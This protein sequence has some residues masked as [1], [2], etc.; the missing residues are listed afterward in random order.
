MIRQLA[1]E[2]ELAF[3]RGGGGDDMDFQEEEDEDEDINNVGEE[4]V[5][6]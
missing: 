4:E 6:P 2:R 1:Q 3:Q 5:A